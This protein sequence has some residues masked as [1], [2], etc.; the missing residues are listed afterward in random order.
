MGAGI[1]S[2]IATSHLVPAIALLVAGAVALVLGFALDQ[3][4][5]IEQ[6]SVLLIKAKQVSTVP[7]PKTTSNEP[8]LSQILEE[9]AAINTTPLSGKAFGEAA[10]RQYYMG[11]PGEV[12]PLPAGIETILAKACPF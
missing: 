1:G 4:R 7:P 6:G 2:V 10:W 11:D 3:P 5:P 9:G 12:P 8:S